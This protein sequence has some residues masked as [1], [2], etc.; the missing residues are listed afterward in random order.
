[1]KEFKGTQGDRYVV[2]NWEM[3]EGNFHDVI[4]KGSR[5]HFDVWGHGI[6][7]EE[8][9]AN[10]QLIAA[11]PNLLKACEISLKAFI[12][13][14]IKPNQNCRNQVQKAISKALAQ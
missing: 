2:F 6:S 3:D 14:G 13:L 1:M 5:V 12:E 7:E 11:A 10:A 9:K 8:N 4:I